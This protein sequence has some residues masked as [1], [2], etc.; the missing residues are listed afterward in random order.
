MRMNNFK[1]SIF[2]ATLQRPYLMGMEV[3]TFMK[4]QASSLIFAPAGTPASEAVV[5]YTKRGFQGSASLSR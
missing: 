2:L 1:T 3:Q 4:S 5:W